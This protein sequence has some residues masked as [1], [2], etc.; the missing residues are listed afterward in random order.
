MFVSLGF[1]PTTA[2]AWNCSDPLA[3]RVPV[4]AGTSGTF[5][6]G[7]GQL[8]LGT[9]SEGTKGQLYECKVPTPPPPSTN[10]SQQQQQQQTANGG[11]ASSSSGATSTSGASATGGSATGGSSSSKSGV[12]NSGNSSATGGA[13]GSVSGS[14]NSNVGPI[15]NK[16]QNNNTNTANGGAGGQ[17]GAGGTASSTATGGNQSQTSNSSATGNGVGNGNGSNNTTEN[18]NISTRIPVASA[19]AATVIPTV[20]CFKGFGAGA[21]TFN[22]G[23]SFTGGKVD[24]GCDAREMAR[25]YSLLGSKLAAC[26]MMVNIKSSKKAGIT[27]DDCMLQAVT[28]NP[29]PAPVVIPAPQVVVPNITIN[30]PPIAVAAPVP[31]VERAPDMVVTPTRVLVGICTFASNVIC[32]QPGRPDETQPLKAINIYAPT[33]V[34]TICKSM[35]DAAALQLK[36]N[37]SYKLFVIGNQNASEPAGIVASSRSNEVRR[38]LVSHGVASERIFT[39]VGTGR[40]RTVE[41]WVGTE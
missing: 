36:S 7:D 41:L 6:N 15:S 25:Y 40:D 4:P 38:Y 10:P 9:G 31:V 14:G 24:P 33:R 35:L 32:S 12:S 30:V 18:T 29:P 17:G 11:S 16:N 37:P 34:T 39:S 27:L 8:F 19:F 2:S 13:G 21:Q 23:A 1:L 20:P 3:S 5:G 28:E 26:K 22:V